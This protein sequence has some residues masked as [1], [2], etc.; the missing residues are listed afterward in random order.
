MNNLGAVA[1]GDNTSGYF[2]GAG[3]LTVATATLNSGAALDVDLGTQSDLLAVTRALTLNGATVNVQ[4]LTGFA[5]GTYELMSYGSL[6]N[7][8]N[9][10]SLFVGNMPAGYVG[11]VASN[12]SQ[13]NLNVAAATV[14]T[15]LHSSA[16]DIGTQNWTITG[17][18]GPYANGDAVE[19]LDGA[20]TGSVGVAGTVSPSVLIVNNSALAYTFSGAGNISGSVT[21]AKEGAGSLAITMTGNTYNG[22]TALGG[23]VLQIVASSTV[24]GGALSSG[25]LGTGPLTVSGGTLQDGGAAETLANG[26]NINGNVTL[27]G[28]GGL[29]FGPQTLGTPNTVTI[30]GAP[31]IYVTAP[32]TFADQVV[33]NLVKDGPGTLSLTAAT[34]SLTGTTLVNSGTLVATAANLA[35]PITLANNATVTFNQTTAGTLTEAIYGA[36]TLNKTGGGM[37]TIGSLSRYAGTTTIGGGTLQLVARRVHSEPGHPLHHGW[38]RANRQW[39]NDCRF[40]RQWQRRD[41]GRRHGELHRRPV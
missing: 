11:T 32:T 5:A 14:W 41:D 12:G 7:P 3:T 25:P 39:G 13:V 8:F 2:G 30:T 1:P 18:A 17:A 16:W 6:T 36:G 19:F 26:L 4:S 24:A 40:Q 29:T 9:A 28:T 21:L 34:N 27:A 37:L 35:T 10:A 38:R 15:G 33:G 20:G 31:T 23:G 22:G